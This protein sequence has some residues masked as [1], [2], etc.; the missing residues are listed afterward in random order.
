MRFPRDDRR[1]GLRASS[2]EVGNRAG[3]VIGTHS[4][5][6]S[7]EKFQ[8]GRPA[9][10]SRNK[11]KMVEHKLELFATVIALWTLVTLLIKL[12]RILLKLKYIQDKNCAILA[13]KLRK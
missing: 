10:N 3:L 1:N 8:P 7:Y 13:A 5:V 2:F 9:S 6:Y 12:I 4:V 11:T